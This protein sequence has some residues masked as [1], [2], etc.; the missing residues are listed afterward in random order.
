[1][2]LGKDLPEN[3]QTD[4]GAIAKVIHA[5]KERGYKVLLGT[6]DC[7]PTRLVQ[8]GRPVN[9]SW[10]ISLSDIL[11]FQWIAGFAPWQ[12]ALIIGNSFGFS[13]LVIAGLCPGCYVDAIDAEIEGSENCLGSHLTTTIA[14]EHFPGVRL[15]VG[16]SPQDLP[17]AC[18]FD[19]YDFVFIDGLH[20]NE[21]L[22]ADF[23][24]VCERREKD[25]VVY[26]HDVGIAKMNGAWS[27]IKSQF[28]TGDDAAF[29]LNFTSFG[30]AVVISGNPELKRF[31]QNSCRPLE[32]CYYYFGAKHIG[33]RS[34]YRLLMRTIRYSSRLGRF[35]P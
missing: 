15:T 20:T 10:A 8:N 5:Y 30:S 13:T 33:L 18:R 4:I 14:S 2:D 22:M 17:K 24:G 9:A 28:L 34:A 32:D 21:Q 7:L 3:A 26:L 27:K 1:M 19:A 29:D 11:V 35:L 16:Y 23:S 25:S 31:M 6:P 12:R